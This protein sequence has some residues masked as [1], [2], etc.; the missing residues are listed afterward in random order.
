MLP[1]ALTGLTINLLLLMVPRTQRGEAL[2]LGCAL[3]GNYKEKNP[4]VA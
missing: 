3:T 2:F 4:V 1:A